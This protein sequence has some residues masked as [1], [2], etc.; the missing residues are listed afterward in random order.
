MPDD[1]VSDNHS[2]AFRLAKG[3]EAVPGGD[4]EDRRWRRG[5]GPRPRLGSRLPL[6]VH[7]GSVVSQHQ[8]KGGLRRLCPGCTGPMQRNTRSRGGGS[9]SITLYT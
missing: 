2:V 7:A 4:L 3:G 9:V 8:S 5:R 1:G 6:L